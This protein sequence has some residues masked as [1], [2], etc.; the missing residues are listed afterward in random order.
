MSKNF[1]SNDLI[2]WFEI[3]KR[4]MPWRKNKKFYNIWLSE[5][6]LQQTQ[7]KT[8]IP[9]Y[10]KWLK[11]CPTLKSV[12]LSSE[13][14]ILKLWEGL[15]YYS[16]ARNFK[17]ACEYIYR[18]NINLDKIK[19][20][21][22]LDLPGVGSYTAAAVFSIS[23]NEVYP[24]IDGNVKRVLSRLLRIKKDPN[25]H[26]DQINKFLLKNISKDNPCD[27]NQGLMELGATICRPQKANCKVCPIKNYCNGYKKN[28]YML[29]PIKIKKT[30]KPHYIIV[31]GIIRYKEKI[32]I[33]KRKPEA[34]L[35]GLWEF[36]GGKIKKNETHEECLKREVLEEINIKIKN[37][38]YLGHIK[39]AYS[40]FSITLHS[41][42]CDYD[43]GKIKAIECVEV[44][45]IK[46]SDITKYAFPKANH[47][48]LELLKIK[49][50]N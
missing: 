2:D 20:N 3:N 35:G 4:E 14:K 15:G 21:Q 49:Y 38:H 31:A 46:L 33:S 7:V 30:K 47:K 43:S 27:F 40:H 13:E 34:M 26:L 44:K 42:E 32:I 17:K 41:Y 29:Y 37:L 28:D 1:F 10:N 39:H 48:I 16:R 36:P 12:A 25:L 22:F 9:Y 19:Y 6:M 8:V 50:F 5:V 18:N 24:V 45:K 23:K 11:N